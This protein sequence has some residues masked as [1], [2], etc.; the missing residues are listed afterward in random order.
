MLLLK[1][2][3]TSWERWY[4]AFPFLPQA[5]SLNK[6]HQELRPCK[7][8]GHL[9]RAQGPSTHLNRSYKL[10]QHR[11]S[12][13]RRFAFSVRTMRLP[14]I[15]IK[16][17]L[18]SQE[19]FQTSLCSWG[20]FLSLQHWKGDWLWE[21]WC[22]EVS[23]QEVLWKEEVCFKKYSQ[24]QTKCG[25]WLIRKRVWDIKVGRSPKHHKFLWNVRGR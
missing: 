6:E 8:K 1:W 4:N 3:K 19:G 20:C 7:D 14:F 15:K 2:R 21:V 9:G 23:I 24:R 12:I 22:S 11:F 25:C 16:Q 18:Y 10:V 13:W 5:D 17:F